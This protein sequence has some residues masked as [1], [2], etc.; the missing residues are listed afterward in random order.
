MTVPTFDLTI[1]KGKTLAQSFG[2]HDEQLVYRNITAMP[3]KAPVRLTVTGHG[4]PDNWAVRIERTRAPAELNTP[5]GEYWTPLVV[6]ADTLEFDQ[7]DMVGAKAFAAPS[8]LV[9]PRPADL[10]GWK[11]RMQIR[12]RIGGAVLL[13]FSSDPADQADGTIEVDV[14]NSAFVIG[15]DAGQTA[16]ISWSS[17]TYDLEVIRPDGAVVAVIGP[18]RVV[19]APEVTVWA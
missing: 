15:L 19:I 17:G 3:S 4:V 13:S 1:T 8:V 11:A 16:A 9:Y 5:E 2:Y 12:D 18:S 10:E 6:D 14:A 7:L